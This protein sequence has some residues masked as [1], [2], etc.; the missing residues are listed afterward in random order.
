MRPSAEVI[1]GVWIGRA[2]G[3]RDWQYL[4]ARS[5][6][7]LTAEFN[8]C[9]G[10]ADRK[11]HSMPMLDLVPPDVSDIAAAVGAIN[12][13]AECKPLLVHCALGYS[14]SAIAIAA[15][16]V[17]R[18]VVRTSEEAIERVRA[19]R[20]QIVISPTHAAVLGEYARDRLSRQ[21]R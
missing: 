6:L 14:R 4:D 1:P 19:V 13:L 5:V 15:W 2:P 3:A 8:A 12:D 18:G 16:L 20:P 11:V 9:A 17:D 21:F 7:D 10:S